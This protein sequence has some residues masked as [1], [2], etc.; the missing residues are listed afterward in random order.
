MA[1]EKDKNAHALTSQLAQIRTTLKR[2]LGNEYDEKIEP[3]RIALREV[4]QEKPLT[5]VLQQ[6]ITGMLAKEADNIEM[7]TLIS[8][9]LD[10]LEEAQETR[11]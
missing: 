10:V 4:A 9:G 7:M 2:E 11:H 1:Q 5:E 3:V 6:V 8:A